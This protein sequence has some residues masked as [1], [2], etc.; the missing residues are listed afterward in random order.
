TISNRGATPILLRSATLAE[1]GAT[2]A[3]SVTPLR[4]ALVTRA[5]ATAAGQSVTTTIET[6]LPNGGPLTLAL[7]IWDRGRALHYGWYGVELGA[8]AGIQTTTLNLDLARGEAHASAS[9]GT[10][11][12]FGAQFVGLQAGDYSAR[13]QVSAGAAALAGS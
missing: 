8:G 11:L 1:T 9:D 3:D 4:S 12:P 7:D 2:T 13:L 10:A 5:D 6:R